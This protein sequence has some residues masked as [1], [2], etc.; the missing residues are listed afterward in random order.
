MPVHPAKIIITNSTYNI[1]VVNVRQTFMDRDRWRQTQRQATAATL[2]VPLSFKSVVSLSEVFSH[3]PSLPHPQ[4]TRRNL[5][6]PASGYQPVPQEDMGY[7]T[8]PPAAPIS[9][10]AYPP[11]TQVVQQPDANINNDGYLLQQV[12]S[13]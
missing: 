13:V 2:I 9:M 7:P 5:V 6:Y 10:Q 4:Q 12:D 1:I 11:P 8:Y 3:P